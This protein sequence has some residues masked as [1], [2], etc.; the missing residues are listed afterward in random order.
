MSLGAQ[1]A[2]HAVHGDEAAAAEIL[3][4]GELSIE[5]LVDVVERSCTLQELTYVRSLGLS[6]NYLHDGIV[7]AIQKTLHENGPLENLD[8]STNKV[9]KDGAR[10]LA[11]VL[12]TNKTLHSLNLEQTRMGAEGL[13]V[14]V[15]ALHS[16]DTL[17]ELNLSHN[18]VNFFAIT[19]LAAAVKQ[20]GLRVLQ[21]N[22]T[23]LGRKGTEVLATA[24][25]RTSTLETLSLASNS[26]GDVGVQALAN[27]L[28]HNRS[29]LRIDL[30][31]NNIGDEGAKAMGLVLQ[32]RRTL[33]EL[34]L[35][36]NRI[37]NDGIKALALGL[38]IGDNGA[39]ALAVVLRHHTSLQSLNLDSAKIGHAGLLSL[40]M[41][42]EQNR[43]LR[44]LSLLF[45]D[46]TPASID[47]L[48]KALEDNEV[49]VDL[50][51]RYEYGYVKFDQTVQN[52]K[53]MAAQELFA[54]ANQLLLELETARTLSL[55]HGLPVMNQKKPDKFVS[56]VP[57]IV[58]QEEKIYDLDPVREV[59]RR[60][61]R[62][63]AQI[64]RLA[65]DIPLL[66]PY[67]LRPCH[68]ASTRTGTRE[69][70]MFSSRHIL[71]NDNNTRHHHQLQRSV[72][73]RI[74]LAP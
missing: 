25:T 42:L 40:A 23:T 16:N 46:V 1:G 4:K 72:S 67:L 17:R 12:Q 74:I 3:E 51:L 7:E 29:L 68:R 55:R 26:I 48:A 22:Q 14:V 34:R 58:E 61:T 13:F 39:H 50:R 53:L 64:D 24:L 15:A 32:Q 60:L 10:A 37:G 45:A 33:R 20:S 54:G 35:D 18:E 62:T 52:R 44:H 41:A 59:Q 49:L 65:Q 28:H 43:S 2:W 71:F 30:S 11:I 47:A 6:N 21:L 69:A 19:A 38:R 8:I 56:R 70:D 31:S 9:G 5:S 73:G 63:R 27:A 57:D 36:H 66:G